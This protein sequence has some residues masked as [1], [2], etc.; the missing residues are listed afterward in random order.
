MGW[1]LSRAD[2]FLTHQVPYP[3]AMVGSSD[4]NWR[5]RYWISL[6]D[7]ARQDFILSAG[8][9]KYPNQDVM[10]ACAMAQ[11]G[12]VQHNLRVSRQLRPRVD[13]MQVGPFSVEVI[14]PLKTLRFEIAANPSGIE[15]RFTWQAALPAM[16]EGRHFEINR[17]R[18]SHDLARYVQ[19]GRVEGELAIGGQS[20]ALD[21][22][23]AWAERDH[24]WGIRPMAPFP[25]EP[26]AQSAEWNFL[27]FCPIQFADFAVHFY[28]FEA[29]A[30]RPT[31]LSA[32]LVRRDG[33]D[34]DDPIESVEHD[35]HW[36]PSA[37]VITLDG[38]RI[39]LRMFSGKHI[40]IEL[41]ALA[42]RVYLRGGGY[43]VDHGRWKGESHLEHDR[44]DLGDTERLR[45]YAVSSSDH[46]VEARCDGETGY[47]IIE[48]MVRRGHAKY[49]AALPPSRRRG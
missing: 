31:H 8:F 43:G 35:F 42:P 36:V 16:L 45:D 40:E 10:E 22:R 44:W 32:S 38:G 9:G 3:H 23:T 1:T 17:S 48:Y 27:A 21:P 34:E 37:P 6:H 19:L 26:P 47:G 11:C 29:Q 15:G 2:E 18:V 14:E 28:L 25:G 5:E 41:R 12:T 33:A 20:F 7:V 30:G 46:L 4:P 24:S 13:T 49:A 39:V